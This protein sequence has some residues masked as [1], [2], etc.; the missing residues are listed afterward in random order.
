MPKKIYRCI[1]GYAFHFGKPFRRE[2]KCPK[3]NSHRVIVV[4]GKMLKGLV[5]NEVN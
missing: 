2:L 3:C 5:V 4:N 1:C